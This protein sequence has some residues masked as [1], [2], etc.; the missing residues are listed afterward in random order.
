MASF[1]ESYI[2]PII[3]MIAKKTKEIPVEN[4][5]DSKHVQVKYLHP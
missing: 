3:R 5:K 4:L 2:A 1:P